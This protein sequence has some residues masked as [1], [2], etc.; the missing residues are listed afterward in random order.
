MDED[1]DNEQDSQQQPTATSAETK[2]VTDP[3]DLL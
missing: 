1:D 3:F 2:N